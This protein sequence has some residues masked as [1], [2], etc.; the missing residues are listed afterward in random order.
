[1]LNIFVS[2]GLA[3]VSVLL[4]FMLYHLT[5]IKREIEHMGQRHD[6]FQ[7]RLECLLERLVAVETRLEERRRD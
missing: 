4:S 7:E 3:I 2:I 1:M 6:G 5:A